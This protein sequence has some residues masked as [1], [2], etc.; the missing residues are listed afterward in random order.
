MRSCFPR[1]LT[2]EESWPLPEHREH[3]GS[4]DRIEPKMVFFV[5]AL[6]PENR[7]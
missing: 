5:D 2:G 6:L 3:P 7:N 4:K 1:A